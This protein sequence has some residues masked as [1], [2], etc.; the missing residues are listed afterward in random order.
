MFASVVRGR[1]KNIEVTVAI[2]APGYVQPFALRVDGDLRKSVGA[3]Q[4]LNREHDR[5]RMNGR[6]RVR[7]SLAT[8]ARRRQHDLVILAPDGVE[9]AI[10]TNHAG[11]SFGG[12]IVIAR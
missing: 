1:E 6:A 9:P 11:E 3:F 5:R 7:E 8:I 12:P 10:R 2:I 4:R